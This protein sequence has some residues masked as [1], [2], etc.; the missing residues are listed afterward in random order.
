[1]ERGQAVK[2]CLALLLL[3][4]GVCAAQAPTELSPIAAYEQATRPIEIVHRSVGNW[5]DSEMA[6]L[7]V[8]IKQAADECAARK[9]T[10]FAGDQLIAYARLCSLGVNWPAVDVAASQYIDSKD[11]AK[12]QL[13]L[14]YGMK[15]EAAMQA[16]ALPEIMAT[17]KAMLAA[18]PYDAVVDVSANEAFDYLQ[19]AY[20][21]EAMAL[22]AV[23]QPLL[24][25]ALASEKPVVP[26]HTLYGDGLAKAALEQYMRMPERADATVAELD[27]ALAGAA[28]KSGPDE[29][30][31]IGK[32]RRQYG[33]LGK[34]LPKV[35][36]EL[37]LAAPEVKPAIDTEAGAST[38][39]LIFPDWCA[40]CVRMSAAELNQ[41]AATLK[42][43]AV[44]LYA[45][46]AQP[47]PKVAELTAVSKDPTAVP[48]AAKLLLKTPTIVVPPET[49][50][51]LSATD[52]PY[53]IVLDHAGIVRFAGVA[54]E[55]ALKTGQYVDRAT[56]HVAGQWPSR[57]VPVATPDPARVP[58]SIPPPDPRPVASPDP[59]PPPG[60]VQ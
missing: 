37:S 20:V 53:A 10:D 1:M 22:H 19:L 29:L 45:L 16:H 56:D 21:R 9:A 4:C 38:A 57:F 7:G 18:N 24:L 14:A 26:V 39:L 23:R 6:S 2:R 46:L 55:I 54:P 59:G 34:P 60:V 3:G 32:L 25:A 36:L 47:L 30:I 5:S 48:P 17:A 13:P 28:V 40:Q 8:A 15:L 58:A 51:L 31:L 42:R 41:A 49:L 50:D 43:G 33:M 12:P 27:A 11:A 35:N 44:Q 52:F